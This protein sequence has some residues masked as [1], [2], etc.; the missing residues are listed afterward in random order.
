MPGLG[1]YNRTECPK[2]EEANEAA[3]KKA[4]CTA[5]DETDVS[6]FTAALCRSLALY[7]SR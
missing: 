7:L 6:H 1:R 4:N 3:L 2:C 5:K